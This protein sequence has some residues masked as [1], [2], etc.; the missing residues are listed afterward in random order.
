LIEA[1]RTA[2]NQPPAAHTVSGVHDRAEDAP[3]ERFGDYLGSVMA[4]FTPGAGPMDPR[5]VPLASASGMSQ[6]IP[7]EGGFAV[8]PQFSNLIWDGM[9]ASS[10]NLLARTDN[11]TVEGESLT[12]MANAETSRATGSR[13]GGAQAYWI[14][15]AD[16]L[17]SSKPKLRTVKVEPQQLAVL[18]YLTD[19][20]MRNSSVGLQQYVGRVAPDEINFLVGNAIVNGLGTGQ[21]KGLLASGCKIAVAAEGSQ[22]STTINQKNVSKMWK[23]LHPSARANAIWLH[24]VDIEDQL[25]NLSTVVTNVAATEN[26][27]GYA[28]KVFDPER[29]TLKGRPLVACEYCATLGTEG[30]LILV[31][32]KS[33]LSG[34]RGGIDTAMSMHLR[35]DYAESAFRFMFEVDGQTWLNSAITPFKGTNTLSTVITLA[36]R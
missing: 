8:L 3:F 34:T 1:Q 36:A 21:P 4:A 28:N 12:F 18:V 25:D 29:R 20:L 10:D 35:F 9:N 17:T 6:G 33:Y 31:D 5:L 26:V 23:R 24:N 11:Y 30:D 16:Q 7:S 32:M 15:E 14:S 22:A 19:K 13:W 2:P 27:G